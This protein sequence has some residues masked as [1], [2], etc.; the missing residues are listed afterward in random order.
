[1]TYRLQ[2]VPVG[3]PGVAQRPVSLRRVEQATQPRQTQLR[4]SLFVT[5]R[6]EDQLNGGVLVAVRC[7]LPALRAFPQPG[8][9]EVLVV[10]VVSLLAGLGVQQRAAVL[11]YEQEDQPVDQAQQRGLECRRVQTLPQGRVVGVTQEARAEGCQGLLDSVAVVLQGACARLDGRRA[12]GLQ[13]AGGRRRPLRHLEPRGVQQPV[14]QHELAEQLAV[15]DRL[16]VEL[17][18]RRRGERAGVPE[19][20]DLAAVREGAPKVGL[21]S[22]QAFLEHRLRRDRA[23]AAGPLV[24]VGVPGRLVEQGAA[25]AMGDRELLLRVGVRR[26]AR[27]AHR[28]E[29]AEAQFTPEGS[30]P[31]GVGETRRVGR[32]DAC[33]S[34]LRQP[35]AQLPPQRLEVLPAAFRLVPHRTGGRQAVVGGLAAGDVLALRDPEQHVGGKQSSD[36][37]DG[38]ER[39]VA[40]GGGHQADTPAGTEA[41]AGR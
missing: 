13:P 39:L 11:G 40:G 41:A 30:Q 16:K 21:G 27:R 18:V 29:S 6:G 23:R 20:A 17:D 28:R 15:E 9:G 33:L 19:Q 38:H 22:V 36:G 37:V 8:R 26:N 24:Q 7:P 5:E 12:P 32:G 4:L 25:P 1:M 2:E 3:E 10:A 14:Q 31:V 35:C 34:I